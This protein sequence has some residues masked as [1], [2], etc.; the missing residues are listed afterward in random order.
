MRTILRKR[1]LRLV[2]TANLVSMLGSGMNTAAVTWFILQS[3]HSEMALG[4]L[5]MIQTIPALLMLQFTGVIIDREDRRRLVM[6][7]DGSRALIIVAIAVLAFLGRVHVWQ[8]YAMVVFV[9]AGFWMFWP[10]VTA[11][12]QELTPDSEFVHANSF[13]LAGVQGGWLL[14]GAVVGFVYNHIGLGGVLLIDFSTYLVSI[15]C[16]FAVRKSKHVVARPV[17]LQERVQRAE[18]AV[19]RY[20]RDLRDGFHYLRD[21][22]YVVLVGISWSLFIAAMLSQGVVTAPLSD[23]ILHAGAVG[24]GWLNAGWAVGA[25][26]SVTYVASVIRR[27]RSR[28]AVG[29]SMAVLAACLSSAPFTGWLAFAVIIYFVMGSGRGVAGVALSSAMMEHVPPHLMGR[30]QNTFY[31]FATGLQIVL[32]LAVGAVAHH[33]GLVYGFL[34]I[35]GVY[36]LAFLSSVWPVKTPA[37]VPASATEE[38]PA[39]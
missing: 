20:W 4:T 31:F 15:A 35:G 14:A 21:N 10:T 38:V 18:G 5:V 33:V 1:E 37:A 12:I 29:L 39:N 8:L 6:V 36:G 24:Y 17:E 32:A 3:T 26:V 22:Q 27:L 30:V 13:L 23:R 19:E 2:F 34:I 16:Y 11:L 28:S 25:L 7:L 9:S